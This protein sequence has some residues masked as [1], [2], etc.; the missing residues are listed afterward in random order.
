VKGGDLSNEVPPRLIVTLDVVSRRVQSVRGRWFPRVTE[1][2]AWDPQ[3][4]SWLWTWSMG[5]AVN[6]ELAAVGVPETPEKLEESLDEWGSNPFRWVVAYKDVEELV[7]QL[8]YRRDI[9]GVVDINERV[10]RYGGWAVTLS[11][12]P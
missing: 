9:Y 7:G 6:L 12:L 1:Q 2:L 10:L 11:E 3:L 8:P 4:L 5:R